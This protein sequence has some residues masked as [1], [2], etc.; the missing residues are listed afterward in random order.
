[1]K[2]Y[3]I[4]CAFLL[5]LPNIAQAQLV[6]A[7]DWSIGFQATYVWQRHLSFSTAYDGPHSLSSTQETGYTLTSTLFLGRKLWKGAEIFVNPEII[8]SV[9]FSGLHG[10]G[11]FSNSEN[12]KNGELNPSIYSARAFIRQTFNVGIMFFPND[13]NKL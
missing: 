3:K 7:E 8:Q 11:G 13:Y 6:K 1:M 9:D 5:C 12:Q 4:L 2:S 10:F